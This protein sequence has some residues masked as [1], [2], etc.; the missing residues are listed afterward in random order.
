MIKI[1]SA[2]IKKN[3]SRVSLLTEGAVLFCKYRADALHRVEAK[4]KR[5]GTAQSIRKPG[6]MPYIELKRSGNEMALLIF[7]KPFIIWFFLVKYFPTDNVIKE[8]AGK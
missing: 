4:R 1:C 2:L 6:R 5:D 7:L 3:R 8:N